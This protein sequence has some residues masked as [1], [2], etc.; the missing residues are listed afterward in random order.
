MLD[1]LGKQLPRQL[2]GMMGNVKVCNT[3][4]LNQFLLYLHPS[5]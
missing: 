1:E 3:E 2:S 4:K 5:E